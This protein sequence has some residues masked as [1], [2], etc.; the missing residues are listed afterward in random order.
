MCLVIE[1][2]WSKEY[3]NTF[4]SAFFFLTH[5]SQWRLTIYFLGSQMSESHCFKWRVTVMQIPFSCSAL[6]KQSKGS[7]F[8]ACFS[9]W[10][11]ANICLSLLT[12]SMDF[13]KLHNIRVTFKFFKGVYTLGGTCAYGPLLGNGETSGQSKGGPLGGEDSERWN[14]KHVTQTGNNQALLQ[15]WRQNQG[16]SCSFGWHTPKHTFTVNFLQPMSWC[17]ELQHYGT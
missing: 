15:T 9:M 5:S 6:R 13:L 17:Q 1:H 11:T 12:I 3:Y 16:E 2:D 14:D 4:K 8:L 10:I 7:F